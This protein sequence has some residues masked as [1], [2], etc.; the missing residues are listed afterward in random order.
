LR[1][2]QLRNAI[3]RIFGVLKNRFTILQSAS[4]YSFTKVTMIVYACTTLHNFIRQGGDDEYDIDHREEPENDN[5]IDIYDTEDSAR[6]GIMG[7]IAWIRRDE[8]AESMWTQ[9]QLYLNNEI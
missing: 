2:A 3:E 6:E 9:Y 7:G 5:E 8:I 4:S 1:H